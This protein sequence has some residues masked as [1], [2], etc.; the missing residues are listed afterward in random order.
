M[1]T[2]NTRS[3]VDVPKGS[4]KLEHEGEGAAAGAL[5]GGALGA[6]AGPP[7]AVVGAIVGAIAGALTGAALDDGNAAAAAEDER[8]DEEI[9]VQG[10]DL[11]AP[12]LKHPPAR[13][14]A[15]SAAAAGS[16]TTGDRD[17]APAE[18]PFTTPES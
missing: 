1:A 6:V 11:G 4:T 13:I 9:G 5:A 2:N 8:L 10:G 7:G 12:N 3:T 17:S 16:S 14:G 18:G 15:F